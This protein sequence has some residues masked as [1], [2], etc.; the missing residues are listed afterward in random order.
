MRNS[1]MS[2]EAIVLLHGIARSSRSMS[3]LEKALGKEG[4][5][6]WNI[7][8][9]S[10]K[11]TIAEIADFVFKEIQNASPEGISKLH[12]VAYSMGCLIVRALLAK[13]TFTTPIGYTVMLAPPNQGSE[14]A[15]FLKNNKL[16]Q[17]FYGPAGQELTTQVA[18][19]NPFASMQY[20]FG[21]IAGNV[22]LDPI[23]YFILP[24]GHDGKVTIESTKLEGMLDHIVLPCSHTFIMNNIA[25]IEQ[26]KYFLKEGR[27]F[28]QKSYL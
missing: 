28:K 3:V 23:S 7:N 16:Y 21:V 20:P 11:K 26:V 17:Y 13:Y 6:I 22:C 2:K 24:K 19:E 5:T 12:F 15:D 10:T 1:T 4:Y 9:P 25:V 8:Y 27:F 18:K 14:V